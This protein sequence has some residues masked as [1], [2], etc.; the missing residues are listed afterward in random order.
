MSAA[1]GA[2]DDG[3]LVLVVDL[4]TTALKVGVVSL[5]GRVVHAEGVDLDLLLAPGGAATQDAHRWWELVLELGARAVAATADAGHVVALTVTGQWSSTVPVAEDGTP[6]GPCIM[7][8]DSR[9]GPESVRRVG[10]PVAGYDPRALLAWVRRSGGAPS[11]DG[12]DPLGHR[13][14]LAAEQP[15]VH[16]AA[17]WLMEPVDYIAMRLSGRAAATQASMI[18]VWLTDNRR[19]DPGGYDP[20]LVRRSGVD[21]DKLPPLVRNGSVLGPVLPDVARRLG[22]PPGA[23]VVAGVGD[24][25]TTALGSGATDLYAPH[26]SLGTTSWVSCHVP[27]KKTDVVRAF[28]SVPSTLPDRYVV[29]NNH[30]TSGR[31]LH[32]LRGLV[33]GPDDPLTYADLDTLA[34]QAAP[35]AGGVIFTPWLMGERTPITDRAARGGFHNVS[36]STVRADLVRAVLEG[37]AYNDRWSF[38]I[39]EKF[40][41]R[42]LGAV[43]MVGGG[44]R[45][46]LWCQIHADVFDRAVEQV[47]DPD[48]ATLRGAAFNAGIALGRVRVE[49]LPDLTPVRATY[50]PDPQRVATYAR[51]YA[52]FPGLYTRQKKMFARLNGAAS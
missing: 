6:V 21:P 18:G 2:P 51:L 19:L 52:E 45:S 49:D 23:H 35:G 32:W 13:W 7:W 30:E 26:V 3:S 11:L 28:A 17:R 31:C 33:A 15:A 44:A 10:G 41:G 8:L 24:A 36:L 1:A 43:R 47:E 20:G 5:T 14:F 9:G 50:V 46:D 4:G 38:D 12:A 27:A 48:A 37:V 29:L 40:T 16:A 34:A 42:R 25:L 39:L 22:V